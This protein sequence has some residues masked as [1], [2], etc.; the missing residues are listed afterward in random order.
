[1]AQ[2]KQRDRNRGD[3]RGVRYNLRP[4]EVTQVQGREPSNVIARTKHDGPDSFRDAKRRRPITTGTPGGGLGVPDEVEL[5]RDPAETSEKS[6]TR[7]GEA[8]RA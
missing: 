6:D 7:V 3:A 8:E 2:K 4:D 5:K 1:M